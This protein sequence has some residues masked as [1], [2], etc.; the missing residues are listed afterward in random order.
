MQACIRLQPSQNGVWSFLQMV[1]GAVFFSQSLGSFFKKNV[2]KTRFPFCKGV[3]SKCWPWE[4]NFLFAKAFFPNISSFLQWIFQRVCPFHK[5]F[6]E[7]G[8][9]LL[10]KESV[11]TEKEVNGITQICT[12]LHFATW[13]FYQSTVLST[14]AKDGIDLDAFFKA[15]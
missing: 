5:G 12:L 4:Y 13:L 6:F 1:E 11:T 15:L 3:L 8:E 9:L 2:F 10:A 7:C 14:V